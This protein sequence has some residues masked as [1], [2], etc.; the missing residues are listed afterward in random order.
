MVPGSIPGGRTSR[1]RAKELLGWRLGGGG[2][3]W[4]RIGPSFGSTLPRACSLRV[5]VCA[6]IRE[7]P[8]RAA[9]SP[10]NPLPG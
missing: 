1:A 2:R 5:R 9:A 3:A 6:V 8:W 10:R 7:G 4:P